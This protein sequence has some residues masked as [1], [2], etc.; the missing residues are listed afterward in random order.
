M[1]GHALF[2]QLIQLAFDLHLQNLGG[3]VC[4]QLTPLNPTPYRTYQAYNQRNKN[5]Y[6]VVQNPTLLLK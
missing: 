6:K 3:G 1:D 4:Q 5:D 2:H